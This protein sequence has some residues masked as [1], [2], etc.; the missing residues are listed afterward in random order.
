M[1][2]HLDQ[3]KQYAHQQRPSV[4]EQRYRVVQGKCDKLIWFEFAE[5]TS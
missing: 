5:M 4:V 1:F 2:W 3:R